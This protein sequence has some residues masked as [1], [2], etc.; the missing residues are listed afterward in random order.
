MIRI[1]NFRAGCRLVVLAATLLAC[2][3]G[4]AV[5]AT[6][7]AGELVPTDA[8]ERATKLIAHFI[9]NYHY[10]KAG[11]D[12]SLSEQVFER[13]LEA[14]DP[15][16]SFF[17]AADLEA[18]SA[19][20]DSFDDY[21]RSA[22]LMPVFEIFKT[23]RDHVSER[24]AYV[25]SLLDR[26][27]DFNVDESIE[28]DRSKAP[29]PKDRA[30]L[31][32]LWRKRVK[33]DVLSLRIA[34][35]DPQEIHKTLATRYDGLER[36]TLQLNAEDVFQVFINAYTTSIEPHTAYF[37][38]RTSENF[39]IRMSLSLEGIGAVLQGEEEYTLVRQVVP[40]GPADKSG[41][42]HADDRIVGVGQGDS[43]EIA[44]VVGW[45]LDDVVDL[46][47]GP[48]GTTVRLQVLPKSSGPEGPTKVVAITRNKIELEEQAAQKKTIDVQIGPSK[49]HLGVIEL[50][51]FYL[52][53]EARAAG[54]KDYRSTTRDVRKLLV[55]L[56]NDGVDGI[57][58]DL[59]SNGGG[60]LTEATELT[61]LFI[62]TGP[63]VQVRSADG[64]IQ[65]ERDTDP[66]VEY[67]GP[68]AVLVDRN[69]ASASEIFAGAIQD[70][71][72]GIIIGEPTFGKGTVQNLVD[73]NRLD[74]LSEDGLGQLKATIA[75][76]FRIAGASTQ[77]R[78]VVPDVIFPTAS[79]ADD[80]GE[81]ALDNALPWD[82]VKPA[83]FVLA[84]SHL[85]ALAGALSLHQRRIANDEGF[86]VLIEEAQN[87][88][89]VRA[90]KTLSLVESTRRAEQERAKAE[91]SERENRLRAALGLPPLPPDGSLSDEDE[92]TLADEEKERAKDPRFDVVLTEAAHILADLIQG[93]TQLKAASTA[94]H[95]FPGVAGPGCSGPAC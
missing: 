9:A 37:S 23:Y 44:D 36:R 22:E 84:K 31:D 3:T 72:R 17:T 41:R 90:R 14:L 73:L 67:G 19:Q 32:E 49:V 53:F 20:K 82:Q 85:G 75:Q 93:P 81:R 45:R 4:G 70:Y 80:E 91:H 13:Y 47:R 30:E 55:D 62:E 63:V 25:K 65:V 10:K 79:Y 56:K 60:S 29:W 69:S 6:I 2:G 66:S 8:Q 51:T 40:G 15:T 43:G 26:P 42:L 87:L 12:D 89:D 71:K 38:P 76:F 68:L 61:G 57:V 5:V 24:V 52:D 46:I 7:P 54:D 83:R 39:R 18:W 74:R 48:K 86:K 1:Q 34:G 35:K 92:E 94:E 27:F 16:R 88:K 77:H 33:N 59:R 95:G 64:R 50:P 21:L 58:I 11:L 78:G 28:L